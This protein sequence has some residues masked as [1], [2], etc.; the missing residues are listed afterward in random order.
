MKKTIISGA[1]V[2]II[3]AAASA[4]Y[5]CGNAVETRIKDSVAQT[6]LSLQG[7]KASFEVVEYKKGWFDATA[8]TQLVIEGKTFAFDSHIKHGPYS[9]FGLGTVETTVSPETQKEYG[10]LFDNKPIITTNTKLGFSDKTSSI[11]NIAEINNKTIKNSIVNW[12]GASINYAVANNRLVGDIKAPLLSIQEN[13]SNVVID[14]FIVT[15]DSAYAATPEGYKNINW[16]SKSSAS[17]DKISITSAD[18]KSSAK[19]NLVADMKDENSLLAYNMNLKFSDIQ[20]PESA[21]KELNLDV[22]SHDFNLGFTGIPKK[23]LLDMSSKMYEAQKEHKALPEAE[24]TKLAT[25]FGVAYLQGTPGFTI[26]TAVTTTKGNISLKAD[27]KLTKPDT[28]TDITMLAIAAVTRL[29]VSVTPSFSESLIDNAIAQGKIPQTK[30]QIV[31]MLTQKNRFI[32]KNGVYSGTFEFK[33]GKFY[34]NGQIDPELQQF[35]M[36]MSRMF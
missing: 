3:A 10:A 22:T 18:D 36:T 7:S 26:D 9:Y 33:G 35:F 6:N 21:K 23:A 29:E 24:I 20:L 2:V 5:F 34:S 16:S 19:V 15:F 27:A 17:I 25:D 31:A 13:L 30:E 32:L 11:I 1:I 8:K 4:P 12:K 28:N 14:N